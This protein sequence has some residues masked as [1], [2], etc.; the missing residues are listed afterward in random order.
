MV[1]INTAEYWDSKLNAAYNNPYEHH[2][3][4]EH[5][6]DPERF[7]CIASLVKGDVLDI[8]SGLGA[9]TYWISDNPQVVSST[10]LDHA[11]T[12]IERAKFGADKYGMDKAYFIHGDGFDIKQY[13]NSFDSIVFAEYLEHW[14]YLE[15]AMREGL[16]VLKKDGNMVITIPNPDFPQWHCPEHVNY[17]T[18]SQMSSFLLSRFRNATVNSIT[19]EKERKHFV[20][21][22]KFRDKIKYS[23]CVSN[24]NMSE[25]ILSTLNSLIE[26][27]T[28]EWEMVIV[29]DNSD[30]H[31]VDVI[32]DFIQSCPD[33][34][35]S[36][37]QINVMN[38]GIGRDIC[39]KHSL[40][41]Y[42]VHAID[43]DT[44]YADD[45]LSKIEERIK[46]HPSMASAGDGYFS[47]P[48]NLYR[49]NP[50][51]QLHWSED[52][53]I[54]KRLEESKLIDYKVLGILK[55]HVGIRNK[56]GVNE[57]TYV[58]ALFCR[59][60]GLD[61]VWEL[62]KFPDSVKQGAIKLYESTKDDWMKRYNELSNNSNK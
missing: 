41:E 29:D 38:R 31:S 36:L 9:S 13:R 11:V 24:R 7:K 26:Q 56:D 40:G 16:R 58:S 23:L 28:P 52:K 49:K 21:D 45:T 39:A 14:E 51:A 48:S 42:L 54:Y 3:F 18:E 1:N 53:E 30:D 5:W 50:Y 17:Y 27:M 25:T 4:P 20:F 37:Y 19:Y 22:V 57:R 32:L 59:D 55:E 43:C 35:V 33:K 61:R 60:L 8:G 10:G 47:I 46:E 62:D 15:E 12:A 44:I 34:N 2:R 6:D